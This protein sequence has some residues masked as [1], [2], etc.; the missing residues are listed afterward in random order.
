MVDNKKS[1]KEK[2]EEKELPLKQ[3]DD[4]STNLRTETSSSSISINI[5]FEK[6]TSSIQYS[7]VFLETNKKIIESLSN[8]SIPSLRISVRKTIYEALLNK[9][10]LDGNKINI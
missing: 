9:E 8:S 4:S 3:K 7:K 6:S 5:N 1:S 2:A 10:E